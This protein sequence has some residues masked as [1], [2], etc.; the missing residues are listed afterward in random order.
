MCLDEISLVLCRHVNTLESISIANLWIYLS[1][2]WF[3][4]KT[5]INIGMNLDAAP[6]EYAMYGGGTP[7]LDGLQYTLQHMLH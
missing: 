4:E 2:C 3:G 7:N 6:Y 1:G 5:L